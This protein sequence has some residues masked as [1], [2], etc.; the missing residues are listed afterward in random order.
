MLI[1][2]STLVLL[3]FAVAI[4][5]AQSGSQWIDP[6]PPQAP[7]PATEPA[8]EP[9][10]E[11]FVPT[12]PTVPLVPP[13]DKGAKPG[14][15]E[16]DFA[17][18]YDLRTETARRINLPPKDQWLSR[19]HTPSSE[20]A[21]VQRFG[22][23]FEP[24]AGAA[25]GIDGFSSPVPISSPGQFPWRFNGRL[26]ILL[27][28][29]RRT[30]GSAALI[31]PYHVL[32]VGHA[33]LSD[34]WSGYP[35]AIR[36]SPGY[37]RGSQPFGSANAVSYFM[38]PGWMFSRDLEQ[39]IAI[40]RLDRPIGALTGHFGVGVDTNCSFYQ[41]RTFINAS[42]PAVSPFVVGRP[43]VRTG[44]FDSCPSATESRYDQVGYA[45]QSGS[46]FYTFVGGQRVA[47]GVQSHG[48][49][50]LFFTYGD[51]VRFSPASFAAATAYMRSSR[52]AIP[53]LVPMDV[54]ES[55]PFVARGSWLRN[56]NLLVYNNSETAFSGTVRGRVY[57]SRNRTIT[58]SD[59]YVGYLW[60]STSI[61]AMGSRRV[62]F[63]LYVNPVSLTRGGLYYVGVVLTSYD[64]YSGNNTTTVHDVGQVIAY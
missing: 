3:S 51:A 2:L 7:A 4:A 10:V 41:N 42:Y 44:S 64:G 33:I 27:N 46:A 20:G 32:T 47:Y 49:N 62:P 50:D 40:V 36:F 9:I 53:D 12:V 48:K 57:L 16:W 54:Q 26:E 5:P 23:A 56:S 21:V 15:A 17:V 52:T 34:H 13:E 31:D 58:T 29:G 1:R 14:G 28:D 55:A 39:D 11:P 24:P 63:D 37:D 45:G 6:V 19:A 25:G 30:Q 60:R 38:L 59:I 61:A 43:Y 18:E 8:V 35:M 22:P